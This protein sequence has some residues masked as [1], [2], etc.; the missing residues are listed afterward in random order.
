MNPVGTVVVIPVLRRPHRVRP[1]LANIEHATPEPHTVLFVADADDWDE[2]AALDKEHAHYITTPAR[3]PNYPAK[4]N[5]AFAET[6][7][8][9]LFLAADDLH[10]HYGWLSTALRYMSEGVGVVGTNDGG[11]NRR[12][13]AGQHSTHSLIR[14]AYVDEYGATFDR[15]PGVLVHEGYGHTY[16]DD[17]LVQCAQASNVYA[18]ASDCVVEHL[19]PF[20][21]KAELDGV[22]RLARRSI[23]EDKA[24]FFDRRVRL[25]PRLTCVQASWSQPSV[26]APG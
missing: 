23:P 20:A 19:H 7:E 2:L 21:D 10:F 16:V 6:T 9:F 24:L 14:R 17:E 8:P 3:P 13:A 11:V 25:K 5:L 22:Y 15:A 1:L 12:V 26:N 4:V 18:H